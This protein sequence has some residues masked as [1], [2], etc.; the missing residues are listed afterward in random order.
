M[1][2]TKVFSVIVLFT[3]LVSCGK[4]DKQQAAERLQL[5]QKVY[6]QGDTTQA[7]QQLDTLKMRYKDVIKTEIE[8]KKFTQKIYSEILYNKQA[9]MDS[10]KLKIA[11]LEKN[12]I[13]EKTQFDL[14]TQMIYKRQQFKNRWNKSF[15]QVHLDEKGNLYISSNYFGDKWLNH[16]GIRVY[17]DTLQAKT[18]KVPLN[19]VLN[20]HSDFM[21]T[22]WEKVTYRNGDENGVIQF[23]A[24]HAKRNLK[25]VFLGSRY[26]YIILESY[27]KR[28]MVEALELSKALKQK[29]KLQKEID[30]LQAKVV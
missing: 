23:I 21:N 12:F 25:A 29:I 30:S 5:A 2:L 17:D 9:E 26:Y 11:K 19:N 4:S 15:I 8:A 14:D 18:K 24:D 7:L 1:N 16:T 6:A 3:V 28:A 13:K 22:K 20:H 10:L 27:D